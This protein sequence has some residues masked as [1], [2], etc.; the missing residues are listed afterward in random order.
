M[1][2]ELTTRETQ[3][4]ALVAEGYT[5]ERIGRM[6]YLGTETVRTHVRNLLGVFNAANRAQAVHRAHQHGLLAPVPARAAHGPRDGEG[7]GWDEVGTPRVSEQAD[8]PS[9]I[10]TAPQDPWPSGQDGAP[11]SRGE[12]LL[13]RAYHT[14]NRAERFYTEQHSD[15]L[16]EAMTEFVGRVELAFLATAD[17]AG[18]ADCSLR[19]GPP[20]FIRVLAGST[21]AYPEYRGNGVLA[22]LGNIAENPQIGLLLVD[23][24]RDVIGLHINGHASILDDAEMRIQHPSLPRVEQPGTTP[25]RWVVLSVAEA[26]IHCRK[27]IPRMIPAKHSP[28]AQADDAAASK[29]S[30]GSDYFGLRQAQ[31]APRQSNSSR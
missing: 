31:Q 1:R 25:Q 8:S 5:N 15:R 12:H 7:P 29:P 14:R 2:R 28:H 3:V 13:Q 17:A 30:R 27:H 4:L 19:A 20:G 11:G 9:T 21:I 22:S 23:F 18:A 10:D 6:V 16:N 26:Y 24:T